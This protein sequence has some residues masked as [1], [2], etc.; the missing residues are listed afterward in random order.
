[1]WAGGKVLGAK[2]DSSRGQ[3]RYHELVHALESARSRLAVAIAA[4]S[5]VTP[6]ERWRRYLETEDRMRRCLRAIRGHP[7]RGSGKRHGW[8][9]A[10]LLLKQPF[11]AGDRTG[12][13]EAH[14]LCQHLSEVLNL[15]ENHGKE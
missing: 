2:S 5:K 15:I 12:S 11:P 14:R 13:G 4:E 10:L 6:R 1:M 7:A 3:H 9:Q 8:S